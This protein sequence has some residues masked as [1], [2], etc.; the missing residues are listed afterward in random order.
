MTGVRPASNRF[1]NYLAWAEKDAPGAKTINTH[2]K[3][4]GYSTISIGKIF[5]HAADNL[6]GWSEAP[7]RPRGS[8]ATQYNNPENLKTHK[9][10]QSKDSKPNR[11]PAF[12][13]GL[14]ED[15][16]YPDGKIAERAIEQLAS[17]EN[18][19]T[20]FFL[21]VG[22]LKP[23]LPFNCPK[24]YWD[25]YD[26]ESIQLPE[27]Y[28]PPKDAPE[29]AVHNFGEL[30]SYHGIPPNGIL[31]PALARQLIQGYYACVSYTDAQIGKILDALEASGKADNTIIILWGDHGWNLGEH[32]MWCK[33]SCFEVSLHAPLIISSP[34][35]KGGQRASALT[36]FI[37]IYPTLCELT[38]LPQPSHLDGKSV[39]PLMRNPAAPW[40]QMAISRYKNG[41]S[42]RTDTYRFTQYSDSD[43]HAISQMLYDHNNDPHENTNIIKKGNE[44]AASTT[45]L[46]DQLKKHKGRP[47]A[48]R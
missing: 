17:F 42:I 30:R 41:D 19:E 48:N 43:G 27:N 1:V 36:E 25:L 21:A 28:Y 3:E 16:S 40:P 8:L 46:L 12:E 20:P 34:Q 10:N 4:N 38:N 13:A 39:V 11:G 9:E 7:W 29:G 14:V 6:Q 45:D 33:H 5:H 26:P 31:K 32:T 44:T 37:D 23:H 15:S 18:K 22:F 47:N 2:F 24:K 35:F